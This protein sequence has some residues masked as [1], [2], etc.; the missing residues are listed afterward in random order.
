MASWHEI[1]RTHWQVDGNIVV[2]STEILMLICAHLSSAQL[3]LALGG[4]RGGGSGGGG[5]GEVGGGEVEG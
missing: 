1:W 3:G 2:K 5:G 4:E